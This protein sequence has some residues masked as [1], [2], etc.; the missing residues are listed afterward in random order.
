MDFR[1]LVFKNVADHLSFTKASKALFISQPAVTRHIN[2]LEK[3][4]EKALFNRLGN[5]ISLTEEGQL[6]LSYTNRILELY[7]ELETSFQ[8]FNNIF[9]KQI[10]MGAST[11]I[12][13]YLLPTLF[14]NLRTNY[15][16]T[17]FELL[18]DNS[19]NI[20]SLLLEKKISL[21][22][23]EGSPS[24]PSIHYETFVKD[25][26]VLVTKANNT[27][28]N[29]AKGITIDQLIQLPL[30]MREE[31]S[32]TRKIIEQSLKANQINPINLKIDMIL[33]SSESIK[34]YLLHSNSFAF[35]SIHSIVEELRSNKFRIIDIQNLDM[36]RLFYFAT[37]H[38]IHTK[39]ITTLKTFFKSEYKA[40][41]L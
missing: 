31:G 8:H 4:Y 15:P 27:I 3:Q 19:E 20:E 24:H 32:G 30:V 18:N 13:Q 6:F 25:E 29:G 11:T 41:V 40:N 23:T 1:L 5:K 39:A 22:F 21:G 12:A 37:L 14:F 16:D 34:T 35:L 9:P 36:Q 28:L 33:G 38:G 26:I 2:E 17:D 10:A 7:Q